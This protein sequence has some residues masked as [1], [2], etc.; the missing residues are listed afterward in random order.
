MVE[1][2]RFGFVGAQ[3]LCQAEICLGGSKRIVGLFP[4]ELEVGGV[5]AGLAAA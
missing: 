3:A 2:L 5:T 4:Q 1:G